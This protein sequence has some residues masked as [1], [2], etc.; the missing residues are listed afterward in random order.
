MKRRVLK[1]RYGRA[2][3]SEKLGGFASWADL[4]RFFKWRPM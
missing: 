3:I 1:R 2:A 4:D